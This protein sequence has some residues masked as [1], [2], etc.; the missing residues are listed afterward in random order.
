[1]ILMP[2]S[3]KAELYHEYNKID[4]I[5]ELWGQLNGADWHTSFNQ[6]AQVKQRCIKQELT[7]TK[8]LYACNVIY[9]QRFE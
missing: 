6:V 9:D 4:I 1:M 5:S 8:N 7:K 2:Y 3:V